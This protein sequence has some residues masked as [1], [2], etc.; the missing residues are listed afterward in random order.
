MLIIENIRIATS[1]RPTPV[2]VAV[3]SGIISSVRDFDGA[4]YGGGDGSIGGGRTAEAGGGPRVIDGTGLWLAPGFVDIHVHFRDPGFTA[5]EDIMSGSHAAARG[6]YTTVCCMPNTS[7]AIDSADTVMY[8]DGQSRRTQSANVFS[9]G[10]LTRGQRGAEL[11]D[12]RGMDGAPTLCRELTGH[13]IAGVSEDGKSLMDEGLMREALLFAKSLGIPVMD[14]AE[15]SAL[16]GGCINE[17]AVSKA[18][19]VKGI[20]ATAET[21]I[22]GRDIRLARETGAHIHIQHISAAGS[23]ALIRAAKAEGIPVTAETAPH[24]FA[25]TEEI[26]QS[27]PPHRR[28]LAKMNPPL[29]TEAD[30]A[31]IIEGLCDGTIDCIA[32]DHA[33]HEAELKALPL[34]SAPFGIVGLETAFAVSHTELVLGGHMT[35]PQLVEKLSAAPARIIG[36]GRG[37]VRAGAAADLTLLDID[38]EYEISS[39]G[40]ASKGRNTP[41][42]GRKVKGLIRATIRSGEVVYDGDSNRT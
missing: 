30:R 14:H 42:E 40:F 39:E 27:L 33:P 7:P 41:F 23:V 35:L 21:N 13:G 9:V 15:D 8:V 25:L 12:M 38:D 22:V 17:G 2:T 11:S 5:K 3:E 10:A 26:L 6:G 20:P 34:E 24:Y 36:L 31:A 29:R 19:G 37:E 32:T 1:E 4:R 18:L 28:A 16:T